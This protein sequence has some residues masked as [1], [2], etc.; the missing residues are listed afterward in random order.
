MDHGHRD[1]LAFQIERTVASLC[2]NFLYI[3]EDLQQEHN[4]HFQKLLDGLPSEYQNIIIQA[5]Y[6]D[7]DKFSHLRKRIL[8]KGGE[9]T[10]DLEEELNKYK[11]EVLSYEELRDKEEWDR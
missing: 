2:K 3:L 1:I 8:D 9:F 11:V 6:F 5:D 4:S 7:K 10:R